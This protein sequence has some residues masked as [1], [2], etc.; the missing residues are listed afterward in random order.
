M[1]IITTARA[2]LAITVLVRVA[3]SLNYYERSQ[4]TAWPPSVLPPSQGRFALLNYCSCSIAESV[5]TM[6]R[7]PPR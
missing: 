2:R 4:V 6:S 1:I 7:K 3:P 5:E